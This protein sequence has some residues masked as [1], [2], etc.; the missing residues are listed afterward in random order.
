M[1]I[2]YYMQ[3]AALKIL[4]RSYWYNHVVFADC[5]KFWSHKTFNLDIVNLGSSSALAAFDYSGHPELKAANWAMAPQTFV[6][7]MEILRNYC[8]FLKKGASVV[9]PVCPLSCL[10]GSN[11]DLADKYYTILNIASIPHASFR[12]YKQQVQIRQ[13]PWLFY[14]ILPID[15]LRNK[16]RRFHKPQYEQ[17]AQ[18]RINSWKKEFSII[19]FDYDLSL[20]NKDAFDDGVLVLKKIFRFCK[21]RN[22][23]PIL[24]LPPVHKTLSSYFTQTVRKKFIDNFIE[25][26]LKDE[27]DV[28]YLDYFMDE[29]FSTKMFADSFLLN[30]KGAVL[31]TDIV[32]KDLNL[33]N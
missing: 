6:A 4:S 33:H 31:F 32:L 1:N 2:G 28:L 11:D 9:I 17:D 3:R 27:D 15:W 5:A 26:A 18:I 23:Q 25:Q 21:E 7:D 10:G 14:P 29:R 13:Q 16:I 30:K 8:S 12:R 20:V 22:F 24:V 19:D